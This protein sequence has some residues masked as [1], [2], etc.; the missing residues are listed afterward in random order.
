MKA[1]FLG[2]GSSPQGRK[3]PG[4]EVHSSGKTCL[5]LYVKVLTEKGR[6]VMLTV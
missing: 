5:A 6:R 2:Y 4:T 3:G 1:A